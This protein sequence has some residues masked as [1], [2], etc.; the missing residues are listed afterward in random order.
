MS[1]ELRLK[2]PADIAQYPKVLDWVESVVSSSQIQLVVEEIFINICSYAYPEKPGEVEIVLS[3]DGDEVEI[4]FIDDGTEFNPLEYRR[5][6]PIDEPGGFGIYIVNHLM[7]DVQYERRN[8]QNRLKVKKN[9][10]VKKT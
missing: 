9:L 6:K 5:Q 10:T 7:D 3:K 8:E 1:H 4:E 2:V